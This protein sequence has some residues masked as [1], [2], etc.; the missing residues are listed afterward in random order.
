MSQSF[1]VPGPLPGMNEIVEAGKA[2]KAGSRGRIYA[3]MK[4]DNTALVQL[5]ARLLHPMAAA[6]VRLEWR[7]PNRRRDPD[8]V[9]AGAKFVLDGLVAAGI[10]SGDGWSQIRSIRDEF[11]LDADRPGVWVTLEEVRE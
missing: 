5:C 11:G 7:E 10:L 4:R 6:H 8:N 9:R 1:F 3:A 2:G